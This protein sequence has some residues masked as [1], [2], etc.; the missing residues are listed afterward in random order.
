MKRTLIIVAAII[1]VAGLFTGLFEGAIQHAL[2]LSPDNSGAQATTKKQTT[3][4][5]QAPSKVA[6]TPHPQATMAANAVVLAQD[7]FQR[8]DQALWGTASDGNSWTSDANSLQLQ[9]A[10]SIN[11]KAG[12]IAHTQGTLNAILGPTLPNA[13]ALISGSLSRFGGT[14]NFG[15]VLRWTDKTHWYKAYIDGTSLVIVRRIN[16]VSTVLGMLPFPAQ[17]NTLYS[18]R[19]RVVGTSLLAKAWVSSNPEPA[20]WLLHAV[21]ATLSTGQGGVRV[22]IL[23]NDVIRITSFTEIAVNNGM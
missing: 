1:A 21:D 16:A 19:F 12:V 10:F 3:A 5:G 23:F 20:N 8:M 6:T 7:S 14:A 22:L 17:D 9:N 15:V 13:E 11:G 18:I 2:T 4:K